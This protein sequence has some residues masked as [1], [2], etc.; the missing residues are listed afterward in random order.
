MAGNT[1]RCR[2]RD[3]SVEILIHAAGSSKYNL[4][5]QHS[6]TA[7]V[8]NA[9]NKQGSCVLVLNNRA[10]TSLRSFTVVHEDRR[11]FNKRD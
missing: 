5:K 10:V 11:R 7:T 8:N 2:K 6:V 9:K 1:R 3:I 4:L